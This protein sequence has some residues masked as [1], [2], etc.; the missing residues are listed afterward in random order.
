VRL[1]AGA[2]AEVVPLLELRA[3]LTGSRSRPGDPRPGRAQAARA[4]RRRASAKATAK[5]A[6][7]KKDRREEE[8]G[9]GDETTARAAAEG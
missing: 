2:S 7:A 9:P 3:E 1:A 4:P 6:T 8:E 5:K